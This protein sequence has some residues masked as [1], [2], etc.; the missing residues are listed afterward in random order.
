MEQ[1]YLAKKAREEKEREWAENREEIKNR[2]NKSK[3]RSTRIK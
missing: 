2:K 3:R 1:E